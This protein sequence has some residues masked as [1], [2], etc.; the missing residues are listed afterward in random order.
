LRVRV[1]LL[2]LSQTRKGSMTPTNEFEYVAVSIPN[3]IIENISDRLR[4]AREGDVIMNGSKLEIK[5]TRYGR[6][7]KLL[8]GVYDLPSRTF[9]K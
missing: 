3:K 8:E 2:L 9:H 4:L 7:R 5:T 1:S 6:V